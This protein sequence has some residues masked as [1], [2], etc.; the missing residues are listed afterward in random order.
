MNY[1]DGL[2]SVSPFKTTTATSSTFCTFDCSH[3]TTCLSFVYLKEKTTENCLLSTD[4]NGGMSNENSETYV[5]STKKSPVV[6]KSVQLSNE[7]TYLHDT[8]VDRM[9]FVF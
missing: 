2:P 8:I 5:L 7:E 4:P 1:S 6:D 3:E 9:R